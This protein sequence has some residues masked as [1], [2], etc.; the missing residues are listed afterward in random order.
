MGRRLQKQPKCVER[1][2]I[3]RL[4]AKKRLQIIF[5]FIWSFGKFQSSWN[6]CVS[7]FFGCEIKVVADG[8]IES[9]VICD[10]MQIHKLCSS[11]NFDA[12]DDD[13]CSDQIN[14]FQTS[15]SQ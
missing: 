13:D 7:T 4:L 11:S 6:N 9:W 1:A 10:G 3:A 12:E 2:T 14:M 8:A 5:F 15:L